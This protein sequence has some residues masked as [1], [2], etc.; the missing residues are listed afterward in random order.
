MLLVD[1]HQAHK[2]VTQAWP[3]IK[4][5]TA[6]GHKLVA[7]IKV[8]ED[9]R[10]L[11]QN[12]FYWGPCLREIAEQAVVEGKRYVPEAWHELFKRRFLGY[13]I[14]KI[15]VAGSRRK[16]VIRRLRSTAKLKV[17]AM[18]KYLDQVQAYATTELG[19]VFSVPSWESFEL[20]MVDPDTGEIFE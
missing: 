16:R 7:E 14:K 2:A 13:E 1:P 17:K 3:W 4:E 19:V 6:A 12:R 9:D 8:Q 5:M 10:T 18:A 15:T 20:G 11:R